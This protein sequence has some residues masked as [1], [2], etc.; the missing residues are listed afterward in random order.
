MPVE[1]GALKKHFA[2][3]VSHSAVCVIELEDQRLSAFLKYEWL[4][5][6]YSLDRRSC[7]SHFESFLVS[8]SCFPQLS[9]HNGS[10]FVID[11]VRD[12]VVHKNFFKRFE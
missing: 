10:V 8:V 12:I 7:L 5:M 9:V 2:E 1:V 3:R 4:L 6:D 11:F